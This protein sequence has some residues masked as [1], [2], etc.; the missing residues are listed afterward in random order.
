MTSMK[1]GKYDPAHDLKEYQDG[2]MYAYVNNYEYAE[3]K[4]TKFIKKSR[5]Y[6]KNLSKNH[7]NIDISMEEAERRN[8]QLKRDNDEKY[9]MEQIK[10]MKDRQM[11]LLNHKMANSNHKKNYS[12]DDKGATEVSKAT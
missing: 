4:F 7:H 3:P 5:R 10:E 8:I 9:K 11:F 2:S 6:Y 1:T 12:L